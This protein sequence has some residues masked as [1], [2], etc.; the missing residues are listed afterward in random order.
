MQAKSLH[1]SADE[2]THRT[3]VRCKLLVPSFKKKCKLKACIQVRM[4]GL[5]PPRR[6]APDPKSGAATNYATSALGFLMMSQI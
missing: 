4:K 3:I 6:E 1:S 5:E 2:G